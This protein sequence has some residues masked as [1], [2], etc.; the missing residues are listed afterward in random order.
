MASK[1][2]ERINEQFKRE[3]AEIL[4]REVKDPRVGNVVVTSAKVAPDL[5]SAQVYVMIP[6]ESTQA[7]TLTGLQAASSF[8]RSQLGQRLQLRKMPQIRFQRDS[9]LQYATRI[10]QLL[11][12][13]RRSEEDAA[14]RSEPDDS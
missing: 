14:Q 1:R 8:I 10:E 3:I 13:V 7:E 11:Q 2:S 12:E 9:S 4:Q 5:S 6:D